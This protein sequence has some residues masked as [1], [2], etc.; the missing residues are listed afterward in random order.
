MGLREAADKNG[1][2]EMDIGNSDVNNDPDIGDAKQRQNARIRSANVDVN[3]NSETT[4]TGL[5]TKEAD[6]TARNNYGCGDEVKSKSKTDNVKHAHRHKVFV[7]RKNLKSLPQE[8]RPRISTMKA[9]R[10]KTTKS[11]YI[12]KRKMIT[13]MLL[14]TT[15]A[16]SSWPPT[17]L[18]HHVFLRIS[19]IQKELNSIDEGLALLKDE[20]NDSVNDADNR[21]NTTNENGDHEEAR[22]NEPSLSMPGKPPVPRSRILRGS[23]T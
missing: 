13:G 22:S 15:V 18:F 4:D 20:D 7:A 10:M 16:I 17:L 1:A 2:N 5:A 11:A 6:H 23:N 21:D 3:Y 19:E 9:I 12:R 14:A 8:S